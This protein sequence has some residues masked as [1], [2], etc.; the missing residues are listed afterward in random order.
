[1]A[2]HAKSKEE[3]SLALVLYDKSQQAQKDSE[4]KLKNEYD[5]EES[6]KTILESIEKTIK[7]I[8]ELQDKIGDFD[9]LNSH[10]FIIK[11]L[12]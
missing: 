5:A 4:V 2:S 1:M 3:G 10:L 6:K 9:D 12:I 8:K 7:R 11:K